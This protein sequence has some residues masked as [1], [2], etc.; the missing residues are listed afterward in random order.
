MDLLDLAGSPQAQRFPFSLAVSNGT[1]RGGTCPANGRLTRSLN[2]Q[3]PLM[4]LP[5]L[6]EV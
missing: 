4:A 1:G 6:A 3:L 5:A 2:D